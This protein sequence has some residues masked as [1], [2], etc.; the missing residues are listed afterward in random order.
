[1]QQI[2]AFWNHIDAKL[3]ATVL[4]G[5]VAFAVAKFA[6]SLSPDV[7]ALITLVIASVSG[8]SASNSGTVLRT[9][10]EDGNATVPSDGAPV[11]PT[12]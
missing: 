1:M 9:P 10:Q 3:K 6:I 8:Y 11:D 12:L 5:I 4:T 7:S 2:T